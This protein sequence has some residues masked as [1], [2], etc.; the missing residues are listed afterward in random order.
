MIYLVVKNDTALLIHPKIKI[1]KVRHPTQYMFC[2]LYRMSY[3]LTDQ[4]L[5]IRFKIHYSSI[6]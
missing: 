4:L 5:N 1:N 2:S 6:I 3:T